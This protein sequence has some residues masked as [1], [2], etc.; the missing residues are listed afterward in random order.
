MNE[1]SSTATELPWLWAGLGA[2]ALATFIVMRNVVARG[3]A[4]G[5]AINRSYEN[6][7]F[8]LLLSGVILLAVALTDRWIRIGHGP[9]VN[10]FELLISQLFSLGVIFAFTY[11][12][13]PVIR[14]TA[15]VALPLMWILGIW[16]LLLHPVDTP[17]PPTY[18]NNWLWA[19]VGFGK[20]FL[21]FCMVG[22]ALA[23]TILLR[24]H[25]RLVALFRHMP[26]DAVLDHFA[27]RF[28][29][30]AFIFHSLMLVAGAVWAQDAWGRYWS[31]DALETSAFLTWLALGGAIH[32][33]LA[34]RV[35]IRGGAVFICI[36]FVLAFLTYFGAPFY[37]QAA[38]KGV[39]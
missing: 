12:R 18:S 10:L 19:H 7:V 2:Y 4:A 23:G 32:A 15:V 20:I 14:P 37:S 11:W 13:F 6:Y 35:P 1:I 25:P 22:T 5:A 31:W 3:A 34:Y 9:F 33:R 36:V 17:F 30:L 38:H 39:I 27:W 24:G 8:L 26:S 21:G 28:M 29:L 16:V